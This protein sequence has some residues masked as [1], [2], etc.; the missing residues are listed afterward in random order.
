MDATTLAIGILLITAG[1]LGL[2]AVWNHYTVPKQ[3]PL[4]SD[5][6]AILKE[7]IDLAVVRATDKLFNQL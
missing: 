7:E 6:R 4:S 5:F 3:R 1:V 2:A